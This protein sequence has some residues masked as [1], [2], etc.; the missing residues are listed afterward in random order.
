M[1]DVKQR[2]EQII[3]HAEKRKTSPYEVWDSIKALKDEYVAQYNEQSWHTYVGNKFQNVV[4]ALIK[5]N[6]ETLKETNNNF[7]GL[8]ILT[9]GEAKKDGII[10]RKI[11]IEYGNFLLIPDVDSTLVW[12]DHQRP[13]ESEVLAIISCKTSLRERIAQPCYWKLKLKSSKITR[14]IRLLLATTDND[15][16]FTIKM[17]RQRFEGMTRNRII[18]EYELNGI[19]ILR[20]DFQSNWESEKIKRFDRIY[21]DIINMV[22]R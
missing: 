13:W 12:R 3:S 2:I 15:E 7:A 14:H 20:E 21:A 18:G 19:Y 1:S 11:S 6:I 10:K 16:D 8:D 4:H 5:G 22:K 17:A 9:E